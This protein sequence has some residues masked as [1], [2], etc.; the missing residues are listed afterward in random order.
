DR[1]VLVRSPTQ[2]V[3]AEIIDFKTDA[4]D[5]HPEMVEHRTQ[6]YAPQLNAY[7]EAVSDLFSLPFSGVSAKLAFL[8]V[9]RTVEVPLTSA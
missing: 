4:I 7:R 8:S 9:G 6:A 1:L 3:A 5:D 2:V